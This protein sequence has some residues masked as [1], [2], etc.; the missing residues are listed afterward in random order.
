MGTFVSSRVS[1]VEALSMLEAMSKEVGVGVDEGIPRKLRCFEAS[2]KIRSLL[3]DVQ[4]SEMERM[5]ASEREELVVVLEGI[6]G[7]ER[8]ALRKGQICDLLSGMGVNEQI[9]RD[10]AE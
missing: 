3:V 2:L 6:F 7:V 10:R 9:A 4:Q 5:S 8:E 1:A